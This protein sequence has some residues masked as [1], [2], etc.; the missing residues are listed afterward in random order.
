MQRQMA[1]THEAVCY[2]W[3]V[4]HRTIFVKI[5]PESM[6]RNNHVL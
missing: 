5:T 3:F 4:F 2:F 6:F 1:T